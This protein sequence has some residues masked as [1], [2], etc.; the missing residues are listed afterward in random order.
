[1]TSNMPIFSSR[2]FLAFSESE[3]VFER[4]KGQ[5]LLVF[6][7]NSQPQVNTEESRKQGC[8]VVSEHISHHQKRA[9][10]MKRFPYRDICVSGQPRQ[11]V[12]ETITWVLEAV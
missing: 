2:R 9:C 1:M 5:N 6:L 3:T 8:R 11:S 4:V 7:T 10:T 12:T